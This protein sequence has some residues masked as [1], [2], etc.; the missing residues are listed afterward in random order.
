MAVSKDLRA[1]ARSL[2]YHQRR[3][4]ME[5]GRAESSFDYSSVEPISLQ[6]IIDAGWAKR[7]LNGVL[8]ALLTDAGQRLH[9]ALDELGWFPVD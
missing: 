1:E 5:I 3:A 4:L 6:E 8:A 7:H 9:D 2:T